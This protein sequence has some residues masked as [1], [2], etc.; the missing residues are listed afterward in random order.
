LFSD[1]PQKKR[2][3]GDVGDVGVA[4]YKSYLSSILLIFQ[5]TD[6]Q[7]SNLGLLVGV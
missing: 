5:I 6:F 7:T 1:V 3:V 4:I 2:D